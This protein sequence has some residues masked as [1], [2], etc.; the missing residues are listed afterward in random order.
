[1]FFRQIGFENIRQR[2]LMAF[3]NLTQVICIARFAVDDCLEVLAFFQQVVLTS[4]PQSV[5]QKMISGFVDSRSDLIR[6]VT[7]EVIKY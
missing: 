6:L 2:H 3:T 4:R 7:G 5:M 1:M